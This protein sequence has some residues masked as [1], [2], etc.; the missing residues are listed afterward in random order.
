MKSSGFRQDCFPPLIY[1][2]LSLSRELP[3]YPSG[4]ARKLSL[5]KSEEQTMTTQDKIRTTNGRG[6]LFD[7]ILDTIGDTP[8]IRI[9]NLAPEGVRLY[10][11]A[12]FFNPASSVK[13]RLAGS[14]KSIPPACAIRANWRTGKTHRFAAFRC[15]FENREVA[16]A[17]EPFSETLRAA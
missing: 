4:E 13:D 15:Q 5:P 12:E 6:K 8:C 16:A 11:K 17:L 3:E 7:S 9:N 2:T 10:V 14:T 1:R